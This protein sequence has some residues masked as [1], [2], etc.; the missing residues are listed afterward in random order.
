MSL[1]LSETR[2]GDV[3][4]RMGTVTGAQLAKTGARQQAGDPRSLGI[5]G[6]ECG[7][8]EARD[9]QLAL[10][11]H[12]ALHGQLSHDDGLRLLEEA[13]EGTRR[14]GLAFSALVSAAEE[15]RRE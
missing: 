14:V 7:S 9:V 13:R 15:L 1:P 12:Q 11:R 3:L 5:L 2:L 8:G 6:A 4:L 10:L